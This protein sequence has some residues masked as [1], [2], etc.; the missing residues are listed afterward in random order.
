MGKIMTRAAATVG[1][2]C[3]AGM[4]LL[5]A[6]VAA[7][8]AKTDDAKK[9]TT[10]LPEVEVVGSTP[11]IGPGVE[12]GKVPA[13]IQRLNAKD[14]AVNRAPDALGTL[15]RNVPSVNVN[16][17]QAN[18]FQPDL[19]YRGFLASPLV[20]S[21]Q[22][23]A[24]YQN[25]VRINESFG[26]AVNFDL[27]PDIA[28]DDMDMM[29]N[30]PAFGLN[31][32]GGALNVRM[33]DGF[34]THGGQLVLQ[35]G[36]FGRAQG[37]AEYGMQVGNVAGYI[38][39]ELLHEDGWREHSPSTLRR[40]YGDIGWR[41]DK[42]QLNLSLTA[43]DN[44]LT[45]N[46]PAPIQLVEAARNHVFTYPDRTENTLVSPA[47]RATMD[48]ADGIS[49]QAAAYYRH[50]RRETLNGDTFDGEACKLTDK[51][52]DG[53]DDVTGEKI[54]ARSGALCL[55]NDGPVLYDS[56]GNRILDFLNGQRSGVFN[57]S[58]TQTDTVGASVQTTIDRDLAGHGN[59][60]VA[61]ASLDYGVTDFSSHTEIGKLTTDRTV[62]G[63]GLIVSQ[64][65]GAVAPVK[66]RTENTYIGLHASDTFDVTD[67]LSVTVGGRLNIAHVELHDKLGDDL[68]GSHDFVRFN[69]AAGAT[70][71][72]GGG[73]VAYA[74][75]SESNRVP[76]AAELACAD[77]SQPCTLTNFFIADPPLKQVV[78][79]TYE[80]GFRGRNAQ[81]AEGVKASWSVGAFRTDLSDDL[82]NVASSV[83][84][85]GYFK[86]IGDTRRQGFEA[87]ARLT[88]KDWS[89]YIGY[90]FIDATYQSSF[91]LSSPNNPA[92]D[93]SCDCVKVN[94]G[95]HIPSIPAHR[96]KL[97]GGY[98]VT[99]DWNVGAVVN[100]M[101]GQKLRGDAS[102]L[103]PSLRGYATLDLSSGYKVTDN[104]QVFALAQNVTDA[105]YETFG[106]FGAVSEVNMT[107][108]PGAR[109]RRFVTPAAPRAIYGGVKVTF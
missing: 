25:G 2:A 85:A 10:V 87:D 45:G 47:L 37:A 31:A 20:G 73:V 102:S 56:N 41:S 68:N 76:T 96:L 90:A 49:L 11:L 44:D 65:D 69:P 32:L 3:V 78:G 64:P 1:G 67:Q 23:L 6:A 80:A 59:F 97:G 61:G 99:E 38:A 82:I 74:G 91:L 7:D 51:N 22:G 53:K 57:R 26:D 48:L 13:N 42:G 8:S 106:T 40:M 55:D 19:Q 104:I 109:D 75:Y 54:A 43:A 95:D 94:S 101:G 28:I 107:E 86:N 14:L 108:A 29:S 60:F 71:K 72:I 12:V 93:R 88:A 4:C 27:I 16:G 50:Y 18:P 36:S 9:E 83:N 62:T 105:K 34:N 15:E 5:N 33:K 84:G 46:G 17:V 21:A 30:T 66:L 63:A 79:R 100:V 24:V 52:K 89:A 103:N 77:P 92:R 98:N 58:K 70:Y 39:G 81:V 35:G